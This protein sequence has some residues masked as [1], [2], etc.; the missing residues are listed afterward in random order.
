[1]SDKLLEEEE[2][3]EKWLSLDNIMCSFSNSDVKEL[4][5]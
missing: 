4:D 3:E 5:Y 2:E 1:M